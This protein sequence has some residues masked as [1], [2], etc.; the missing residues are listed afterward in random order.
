MCANWQK[1]SGFR[2]NVNNSISVV[3]SRSS[4]DQNNVS[5]YRVL[6]REHFQDVRKIIYYSHSTLDISFRR[7]LS[8]CS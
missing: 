3:F 6:V 8:R 2:P 5:S 7:R 4:V 1:T